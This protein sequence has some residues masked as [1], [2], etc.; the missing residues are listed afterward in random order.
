[1]KRLALKF[2]LLSVLI[3]MFTGCNNMNNSNKDEAVSFS[4]GVINDNIYE[5]TL[6]GIGFSLKEGW[7]F[8]SD[9][10]LAKINGLEEITDKSLEKALTDKMFIYEMIAEKDNE[11]EG[12]TD[13]VTLS[14]PNAERY[15]TKEM[16]EEEYAEETSKGILFNDTAVIE[17]VK[18]G[19][20]EHSS[21]R[22]IG[23]I[24]G[25]NYYQRMVF[26]KKGD[27]M[28][29]ITATCLSENDLNEII[30]G[31]YTLR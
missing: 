14:I 8:A 11:N 18:L 13:N 5:S 24:E 12:G 16:S 2:L 4:H 23:E 25:K 31:F 21:I 27:Y 26:V 15:E 10:E 30:S 7:H 6:L 17:K 3:F 19:G 20:E 22:L 9:E 28:V 1:M 29:M